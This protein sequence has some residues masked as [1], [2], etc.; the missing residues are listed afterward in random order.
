MRNKKHILFLLLFVAIFGFCTRSVWGAEQEVHRWTKEGKHLFDPPPRNIL[1]EDYATIT[2]DRLGRQKRKDIIFIY[3]NNDIYYSEA[4][5]YYENGEIQAAL[6]A[7]KEA[8]KRSS[9]KWVP[10]YANFRIA[11][12]YWNLGKND[13]AIKHFTELNKQYPQN[14]FYP[15][16]NCHLARL[17][18]AKR[19]YDDAQKLLKEVTK[20]RNDFMACWV[21]QAEV[22]L[23]QIYIAKKDFRRAKTHYRGIGVRLTYVDMKSEAEFGLGMCFEE[24][25]RAT[26]NAKLYSD[27][28]KSYEGIVKKF[29]PNSL[30][31]AYTY[32]ARCYFNLGKY[33]EAYWVGLRAGLLSLT[34]DYTDKALAAEGL[35][36]AGKALLSLYLKESD[37]KKK[38]AYGTNIIY[39]RRLFETKLYGYPFA[40]RGLNELK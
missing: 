10:W 33:E 3:Y 26:K 17:Y 24:E 25:A 27:A 5:Q 12:C 22:T 8:I 13:D 40:V 28:I 34:D 6:Q 18:I 35:F 19:K 39:I 9:Q 30:P 23:G 21:E 2:Y 37:S 29:K 38:K 4:E 7:Y 36:Y 11:Y 32:I 20:K 16:V 14:P 31:R 15:E 1:T